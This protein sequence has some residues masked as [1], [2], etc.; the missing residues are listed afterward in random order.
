MTT[1]TKTPSAFRTSGK[2]RASSIPQYVL[3][4]VVAA[5]SLFYVA[6]GGFRFY[7][8]LMRGRE[9]VRPPFE[10]GSVARLIRLTPSQARAAGVPQGF[11]LD[12]ITVL[13]PEAE[14]AGLQVGDAV[15]ALAGRPLLGNRDLREVIRSHRPG[16]VIEV[17]FWRHGTP[18]DNPPSKVDLALAARWK[19]GAPVGAWVVEGAFFILSLICLLIGLYVVFARPRSAN[20]WLILGI[21]GYFHAVFLNP[22]Q[23]GDSHFPLGFLW[24]DAAQTAMPVCFMLFGVYFPERSRIDRQVP[25]L[26]WLLMSPVFLLFP[27][28]CFFDYASFFDFGLIASIHGLHVPLNTF[29]NVISA[30]C[31]S[32]GFTCLYAKERSRSTSSDARRRLRVLIAG[33]SVGLIP[34]FL[35]LAS[36]L[37]RGVDMGTGVPQWLALCVFVVLFIFP[38]TLAYVVVVQRALDLRIL[39]RQGT[40]YFFAK[41]SIFAIGVLLTTW[42]AYSLSVFFKAGANQRISDTIRIFVIIGIFFVYRTL[43]AKRLQA[44]VDQKFFRE[45]YSTEQ[46]LSELS[47]EARS[48]TETVPLMQTIVNRLGSTLHIDRIAVFLWSG[49]AF[50]LQ[51]ATGLPLDPG[52]FP[53]LSASSTTITTLSRPQAKPANVYRDDPASWL[54]DASDAERSALADL[55][56]ELLVPLPGSNRLIGVIALGPKSSEEPYSRTDRHLL[57]SVASQTGLALENAE[58]IKRLTTEL[59]QRASLNREIE[60]AREVQ[61]RLFPQTYPKMDG[62]D[63]AGYCRPAHFIGGDYY[64]FF[65]IPQPFSTP[66]APAN[67]LAIA[68]GDISGKG[69]SAALLMASLRASLR[70]V[71]TL[72][73]PDGAGSGHLANL[74]KHVNDLVYEASTT[75]RYA[76]FFYAEFD[77]ATRVLTYVNAGHNCPVILRRNGLTK[78]AIALMPTGTVVGLLENADYEQDSIQLQSG[79]TLLAFT[80]GIS[81]A[82]TADDEEWGEPAMIAAAQHLLTQPACSHSANTLLQCLLAQADEFTAGAPQHDDMTLLLCMLA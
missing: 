4:A 36:S 63:L 5:V 44:W 72:R 34:F 60:I 13:R 62:I 22:G 30:L 35:L 82:M 76:T 16:D 81:E 3:L 58:L 29:E 64:D 71:A 47:D 28:D 68:V 66:K 10:N 7:N 59:S 53:V 55:S 70:S 19:D 40:K 42:M 73:Q 23:Y 45:A 27:I 74:M 57:Q 61:E 31:I 37:I 78:E 39:L 79:D 6:L 80:D 26:K 52:A 67:R 11:A 33:S 14:S 9:V 50:Q 2:P 32:Y 49:E 38:L 46:I 69:I 65:L 43:G 56:T 17:K 20:A 51:F 75:N 21:L 25:W 12:T 77:P 8:D 15:D 18:L 48:F 41:Q 1:I 54:V 24:G